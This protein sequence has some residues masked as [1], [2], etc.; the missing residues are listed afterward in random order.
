MRTNR[1]CKK[2]EVY[3]RSPGLNKSLAMQGLPPVWQKNLINMDRTA[4]KSPKG[5]L[6]QIQKSYAYMLNIQLFTRCLASPKCHFLCLHYPITLFEF[7]SPISKK[8][9]WILKDFEKIRADFE[10][11]R[12]LFEKILKGN[13][14]FIAYLP[15]PN[16]IRRL[17]IKNLTFKSIYQLIQPFP[18]PLRIIPCIAKAGTDL[19]VY[20]FVCKT[21]LTLG[22][23]SFKKPAPLMFSLSLTQY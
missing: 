13:A 7:N 19:L 2:N 14:I 6:I 4:P 20:A 8:R 11:F 3:G 12:T 1:F 9:A 5:I 21:S 22:F 18:T 23:S 17:S 15:A 10:G 16:F